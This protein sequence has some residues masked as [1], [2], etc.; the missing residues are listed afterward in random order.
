MITQTNIHTYAHTYRKSFQPRD[1]WRTMTPMPLG[2]FFKKIPPKVGLGGYD[3]IFAYFVVEAK[4]KNTEYVSN[5]YTL[6][7][8]S[9]CQT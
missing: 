5:Q 1:Q 6:F 3:I 9:T 8:I 2:L 7:D 4:S